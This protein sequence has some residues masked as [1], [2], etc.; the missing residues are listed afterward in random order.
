MYAVPTRIARGVRLTARFD[1]GSP[2]FERRQVVTSGRGETGVSFAGL[3]RKAGVC[4]RWRQDAILAQGR[5]QLGRLAAIVDRRSVRCAFAAC[6][7]KEARRRWPPPV[8]E[9]V[10]FIGDGK[11][12]RL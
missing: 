3:S 4:A 1:R 12:S 6:A 5:L 8:P 10:D 7:A 11:C 9:C 2:D